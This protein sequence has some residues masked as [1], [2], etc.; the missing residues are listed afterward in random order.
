M[1]GETV[2]FYLV[3]HTR[4]RG[5]IEQVIVRLCMVFFFHHVALGVGRPVEAQVGHDVAVQGKA[6]VHK[7]LHGLKPIAFDV[8]IDA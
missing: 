6:D 7:V 2:A 3:R 1:G 4:S 8:I 5:A